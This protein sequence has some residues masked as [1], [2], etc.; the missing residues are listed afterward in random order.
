MHLYFNEC[1]VEAYKKLCSLLVSTP[2]VQP[3]DFSKPFEVLCDAFVFA[4]GVVLGQKVNKLS[5]LF[6]MPVEF[7]LM[8]KKYGKPKLIRWVHLPQEFHLKIKGRNGLKKFN[9]GSFWS[10]YLVHY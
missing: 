8:H 10:P 3:P 9:Y 7:S 6:I 5:V 4:I 1:H 2:I